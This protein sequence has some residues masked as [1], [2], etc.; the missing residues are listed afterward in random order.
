M[1]TSPAAPPVEVAVDD[2]EV[3]VVPLLVG[4]ELLVEVVVDPLA[5]TDPLELVVVDEVLVPA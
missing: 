3:V 4:E 1:T 5:T 2:P